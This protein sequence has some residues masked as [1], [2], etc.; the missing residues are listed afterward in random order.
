MPIKFKLATA[1]DCDLL[2]KW[3]ND[4]SV[5]ENS[6]NS[7]IINYEEHKKWLNDSLKSD[8]TYIYICYSKDKPIGQIRI[9]LKEN[10]GVIDYSIDSKWRGKGYGTLLLNDIIFFIQNKGLS[11][12]KLIG[13][14]KHTNIVSQKAFMK[15]GY[16][17]KYNFEYM[18]YWMDIK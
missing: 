16:L 7:N 4:T 5:R 3:A 10:T 14:V 13:K 6:F 8:K 15:A 17:Q 11:I 2:F 12:T 9:D 1:S 18:E